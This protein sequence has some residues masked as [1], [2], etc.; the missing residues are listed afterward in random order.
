VFLATGAT[1]AIGGAAAEGLARSGATVVLLVRDAARAADVAN[2][3]EGAGGHAELL[4]GD[5]ARPDSLRSAVSAFLRTHDRLDGLLNSAAVMVRRR[6]TTPEGLESMFATNHLGP[7]LLTGLLLPVLE[8]AAPARVLTVSAPSTV[9][10]DLT[11]LQSEGRFRWSRTFG[12]TKTANLLFTFA[13]ARRLDPSRVTANAFHPGLVRSDL[14]RE[15]PGP[16]RAVL[17]SVSSSPSKAGAAI[18]DLLTSAAFAGVTGRFFRGTKAIDP[19]A[20]SQDEATQEGL[21]R[22]SERLSGLAW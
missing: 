10:V 17:R 11:D 4:V 19:P 1:G 9:R 21:W 7:F 15:M 2:R 16:V 12:M 14:T 8:A 6:S 3:V 22:Q 20:A 18:T 5:L 13:L